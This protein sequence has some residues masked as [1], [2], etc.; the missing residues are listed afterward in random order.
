MSEGKVDGFVM[1]AS[2]F[3]C[4]ST[5]NYLYK[6]LI[7]NH[8]WLSY[9]N[10]YFLLSYVNAYFMRLSLLIFRRD[11]NHFETTIE[12]ALRLISISDATRS[13]LWCVS[14]VIDL[15]GHVKLWSLKEN[16]SATR[17]DTLGTFET[18]SSKAFGVLT[19]RQSCYWRL[20][21]SVPLERS[22][23]PS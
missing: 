14:T 8:L 19:L 9:N 18:V 21:F 16:L 2:H 15:I 10:L 12:W 22:L 20:A 3:T 17:Q 4:Y 7:G 13:T 11:A 23:L 5:Y 1:T 6:G